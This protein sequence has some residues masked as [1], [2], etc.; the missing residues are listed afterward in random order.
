MTSSMEVPSLDK[1][2]SATGGEVVFWELRSRIMSG[3]LAPGAILR[4][5][6]FAEEFGVSRTPVREALQRLA[7][8]GLVEYIPN[9]G[10]TVIGYTPEQMIETYYVRATLESRAAA[11]A[12]PRITPAELATLAQLIDDMEEFVPGDTAQDVGELGRIN[13][14]FHRLIV[15]ASGSKMLETL[16]G[17]VRQMPLMIRNFQNYGETF[18]RRVNHQHR[19]ILTALESGDAEWAEVAMKSHIFAARN[20]AMRAG[21]AHHTADC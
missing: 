17:T 4:A 9:R 10:A 3:V 16:V 8:T 5:Q 14:D 18:R 20:A 19:D 6:A 11:L 2:E 1:M 15:Q 7:E 21:R 12:A 13:I